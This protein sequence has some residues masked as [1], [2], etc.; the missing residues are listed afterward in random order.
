MLAHLVPKPVR[1][2]RFVFALAGALGLALS[3]TFLA[4]GQE[5]AAPLLMGGW[6]HIGRGDDIYQIEVRQTGDVWMTNGPMARVSGNIIEAGGNFAFEGMNLKGKPYRC[7]YY[8]T[9]LADKLRSVWRV[10]AHKGPFDCQTGIFE[11]VWKNDPPDEI[12]WSIIE[13]TTDTDII[14]KF[15]ARFPQSA[16]RPRAEARLAELRKQN[17][18]HGAD[19]QDSVVWV[20][21]EGTSEAKQY[22]AFLKRFPNSPLAE[23]ARRKL[24][25][26]QD[27]ATK[28]AAA[29]AAQPAVGPVAMAT[30]RSL[31]PMAVRGLPSGAPSGSSTRPCAMT[32]SRSP[33]GLSVS[34]ECAL[35]PKDVFKECAKCPEMVVVPAGSFSMGS[36]DAEQE[37]GSDEGWL[38]ESP[39]HTVAISRQFAVGRFAVTFEEWDACVADGGCNGYKPTDQGWGR[40]R[41]PVINVSWNDAKA[42]VAWISKK[43]GKT[44]RLLTEAEREYVTRAGTTTPFWWGD[45]ISTGKA[46]YDGS[47]AYAGGPKG[48]FR[49]MTFPVDS[50]EPNPF[51]LYQVH[52]NVLDWVE[53]CLHD[54]YQGAPADGSAWTA[55]GDCNRRVM[56]G[57]A[58]SFDPRGVRSAARYSTGLDR[59]L[60]VGGFRLARTLQ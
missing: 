51:G 39:Q 55:G 26:L 5:S 34:E 36:A 58:W 4:F 25:E 38:R 46:N 59:R 60:L 12:E 42:Y 14:D 50:F 27:R 40:E 16:V 57:G 9:F 29:A 37:K 56:R 10:V 32:V 18:G 44:Y 43:T 31:G 54:T 52:G 28:V 49:G 2:L 22:D 30:E 20:F 33:Q 23:L 1:R 19:A 7:V 13:R 47:Y 41:R 24:A 6:S 21:I 35:K 11:R 15:I 17:E 3:S 45:A 8:I 53:D 48:I